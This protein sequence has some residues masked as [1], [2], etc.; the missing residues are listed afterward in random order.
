MKN[1]MLGIKITEVLRK[2]REAW[3]PK[4]CRGWISYQSWNHKYGS[5]T[6]KSGNRESTKS[7]VVLHPTMEQDVSSTVLI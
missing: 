5:L 4:P 1:L 7:L 3:K 6:S 2:N